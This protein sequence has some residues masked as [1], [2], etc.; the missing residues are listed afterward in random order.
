MKRVAPFGAVTILVAVALAGCADDGGDGG[1]DGG[2]LAP[3]RGAISGLLVDDRFRP[4][5]LTDDPQTEFQAT[6]FVLLQET[7][8]QVQT[9]EN[10]EFTFTDLDPGRYT[11]R[12]QASG[13][14]AVPTGVNVNAGEFAEASVVARRVSS[15][16]SII[17]TQEHAIF[18]DCWYINPV[19][20]HTEVNCFVDLSRDSKRGALRGNYTA[21]DDITFMVAEFLMNQPGDYDVDVGYGKGEAVEEVW[22][23]GQ[24]RGG[25]YGKLVMPTDEARLEENELYDGHF[26]N[27]REFI[28]VLWPVGGIMG[29]DVSTD[30]VRLGAGVATKAQVLV[31]LF[32]GEPEADVTAYCVLC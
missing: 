25:D 21:V 23:R 29:Q 26:D 15:E 13:H 17:L 4:I 19:F 2:E 27:D 1:G 10:G 32:I 12:V 22:A 18:I 14:E 28:A 30:P 20:R 6:G 24:V 3:D 11:L 16:G 8:E 9:T 5:H 31:S 7:G